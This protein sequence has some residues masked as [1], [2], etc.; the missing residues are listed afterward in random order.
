[1]IFKEYQI[2]ILKGYIRTLSTI[3]LIFFSAILLLNIFEEINFFKDTNEKIFYPFFLTLLNSPS[4]LYEIFPFVFLIS[5][6]YY[7]IQLLDKNEINIFKTFGITNFQILKLVTL[8]S[9]IIGY[10]IIFLFYNI[11]SKLKFVYFDLKNEFSKDNKYLAVINNNGIWIKDE[12]ENKINIINAEKITGHILTRVNITQFD[13]NFQLIQNIYSNEVFIKYTEWKIKKALI[14]KENMF[15][16]EEDLLFKTNFNSEKIYSLFSNLSS[17]SMWDLKKLKNEYKNLG[18]STLEI[19][20]H[21]QKIYSFPIYLM[22]MSLFSG[23]IMLNIK[24]NKPRLFNLGM[25]V[26]LSVII[27]YINYFSNSLGKNENLPVE[28][29]I[30]LPL[31]IIFIISCVG[32]VKINEK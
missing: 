13:N 9:L 16:Q 29:S 4:I 18:Y 32:L 7:F 11:S 20:L 25:G 31:I 19:N 26:L 21:F 14:S 2:Y 27:Y 3:T 22:I 1:M 15:E 8:S 17:L 5:T 12:I 28:I 6:Q 30:W 23:I 10:L 24:H